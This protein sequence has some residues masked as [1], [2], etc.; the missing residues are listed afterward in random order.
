MGRAFALL[1]LVGLTLAGCGSSA[2]GS[3]ANP[4][5]SELSYFP[6]RAPFVLTLATKPSAGAQAQNQALQAKLPLLGLVRAAGLARLQQLGINY[7]ADIKPLLGNRV[8]FGVTSASVK[9]LK[10]A[11]LI[12]FVTRDAGKLR[13]LVSKLHGVAAA[14][15]NSGAKLYR[16]SS[17]ELAVDGATL[18]FA[19]SV[20]AVTNALDRH[21][22]NQGI[23]ETSYSAAVSGLDPG[24]GVNVFGDLTNA[25]SAPKAA[26]ARRVPW[27][28]ALRGYGAT[29]GASASGVTIKFRLD[30]SG[31]TLA[32]S[33]LPFA[34]GS[35]TP[36]L[37]PGLPI[38]IGVR[39]PAQ[40]VGFAERAE[41]AASPKSYAKFLRQEA[42]V[43][44]KTGV[45]VNT[46]VNQLNG[47]LVIDT[48]TKG[49]LVRVGVSSDASVASA[50]A[51]LASVPYSFGH[52]TTLT[53]A[54]G[55][56]YS[57][58]S[59][60]RRGL[61]GV[62]G[63]QLVLGVPPK[64]QPIS[65]MT[66]RRFASA[67][68]VPETGA[69]GAVAF[70]LQLQSLL[71]LLIKQQLSAQARAVLGLLGDVTGSM[72]ATPSGVTGSLTLALK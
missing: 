46:L 13:A 38:Q 21:A 4:L 63:R 31:A 33:E 6:A 60:S 19:P 18:L 17:A 24:A 47:D 15:S 26:A 48:D 14:G 28:A 35:Q 40:I 11:F 54:G 32:P 68:S 42:A 29:V 56:F 22:R 27:V 8:A 9:G 50:L 45:D 23:T 20:T 66:L 67:A 52:K 49:T 2:P 70:R 10:S 59:S 72:A 7:Q 65:P 3:P 71:A 53:S 39:D 51:K 62:I 37:V 58:T 5:A 34:G 43:R 41:Q 55:G 57:F 12:A 30:T 61:M 44:R 25:L 1:L 64:G 69:A 36:G 16:T